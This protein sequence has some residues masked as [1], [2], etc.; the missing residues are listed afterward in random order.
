MNTMTMERANG[1]LKVNRGDVFLADLGEGIGSEQT[2]Y[3][4]VLVLSNWMCNKYSPTITIAVISSKLDKTKIPTQVPVSAAECGLDKDS[5]VFAEQIRTIDKTRLNK[6]VATFTEEKMKEVDK[7]VQIQMGLVPLPPKERKN[8]TT[9]QRSMPQRPI[10][11]MP[12]MS[13]DTGRRVSWTAQR[14]SN[15]V[16]PSRNIMGTN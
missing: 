13:T 7:A 6:K 10:Q 9:Q 15:F 8:T 16:P 11:Q 3:R 5:I 4:P 1:E 2:G 12:M 14:G